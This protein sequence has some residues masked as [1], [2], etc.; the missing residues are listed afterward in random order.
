[1]GGLGWGKDFHWILKLLKIWG[2]IPPLFLNRL[3][4]IIRHGDLR[5]D[6]FTMLVRINFQRERCLFAFAMR[7]SIKKIR[8]KLLVELKWK[9]LRDLDR[10]LKWNDEFQNGFRIW[11]WSID[12]VNQTSIQTLRI[13]AYQRKRGE[14]FKGQISPC[15]V[16]QV[17]VFIKTWP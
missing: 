12:H 9:W 8:V 13:L 16:V 6:S 3:N 14:A 1:M 15:T 7:I 5:P 11:V 10:A 17:Q 4:A 2:K